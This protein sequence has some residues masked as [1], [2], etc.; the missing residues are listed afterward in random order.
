MAFIHKTLFV[1]HFLVFLSWLLL[2]L[3]CT[4]ELSIIFTFYSKHW[5]SCPSLSCFYLI[6]FCIL[7]SAAM[8]S[9][10]N[11]RHHY[12]VWLTT[13]HCIHIDNFLYLLSYWWD[14]FNVH[15][16][17]WKHKHMNNDF[18][19]RR[20]RSHHV[21]KQLFSLYSCFKKVN[22]INTPNWQVEDFAMDSTVYYEIYSRNN[23]LIK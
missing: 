7:S 4:S 19:D 16:C 6:S 1:S 10:T 9:D 22:S 20:A 5:G 17:L 13:L 8:Y 12:C 11:D 15:P 21:A 18:H 14:A 23:Y 2:T 3:S